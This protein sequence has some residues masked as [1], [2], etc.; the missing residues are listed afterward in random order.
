[1]SPPG[2]DAATDNDSKQALDQIT[3]PELKTALSSAQ[4]FDDIY[5]RL[6]QRAIKSYESAGR[7]RTVALLRSDLAFVHFARQ[8]YS[9]AAEIWESLLYP[10][11]AAKPFS[12]DA[13]VLESLAQLEIVIENETIMK[14]HLRSIK[15]RLGD[16]DGLVVDMDIHSFMQSGLKVDLISLC[17]LGNDSN[18]VICKTDQVTILPGLNSV[19]LYCE[20][21][22][23]PG[24]YSPT[25]AQIRL[26]KLNLVFEFAAHVRRRLAYRVPEN[27]FSLRTSL[28]LPDQVVYGD[29]RGIVTVRIITRHTSISSGSLTISSLSSL[30]F[31]P[32]SSILFR[33]VPL[34]NTRGKVARERLID[35]QE[36][37]IIL[38]ECNENEIVEFN[39]SFATDVKNAGDQKFKIVINYTTA[40]GKNRMLS[41]IEKTIFPGQEIDLGYFLDIA[42]DDIVKR[43][44]SDSSQMKLIVSYYSIVEEL[45][46]YF[47]DMITGLLIEAKLQGYSGFIYKHIREHYLVNL[48][49]IHYVLHG[50]LCLPSI[51]ARI[52]SSALASEDEGAQ[53]AIRNLLETFRSK[54]DGASSQQVQAAVFLKPRVIHFLADPPVCKVLLSA[55][56]VAENPV[57]RVEVGSSLSSKLVIK[58]ELWNISDSQYEMV[59]DIV[60]DSAWMIA[61]RKRESFVIKRGENLEFELTLVPI[62]TG[63]LLFPAVKLDVVTGGNAVICNYPSAKHISVVPATSGKMLFNRDSE[64][65]VIRA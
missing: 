21:V 60:P 59:Y 47:S 7:L 45:D 48:N 6:T 11:G 43:K 14:I 10:T 8:K 28:S 13:I 30:S 25:K 41:T 50:K 23:I 34:T 12:F 58:Q 15:D 39:L 16:D 37:K 29:S 3:H 32:F 52:L 65:D 35:A 2:A 4:H 27:L 54:V 33:T 55:E 51:D 19:K 17:I 26:G 5:M 44:A 46:A 56:I 61:G 64:I 31:A 63:L 57:D 62:H 49:I 1:M 24:L 36:S 18:E 40:A 53:A 42:A 9:V 20:K 38:P 22:T